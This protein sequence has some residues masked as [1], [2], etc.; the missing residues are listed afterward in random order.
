[1][2]GRRERLLRQ[3][4]DRRGVVRLHDKGIA[5]AFHPCRSVVHLRLPLDGLGFAG[6]IQHERILHVLSLGA[7]VYESRDACALEP[8]NGS[9][10]GGGQP[11]CLHVEGKLVD[12][13]SPPLVVL[14]GTV[15]PGLEDTLLLATALTPTLARVFAFALG[16]IP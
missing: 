6:V 7:G 3:V 14:D 15:P 2:T 9:H 16:D 8:G 12:V 11:R 5:V 4:V 1:M 10:G 13:P